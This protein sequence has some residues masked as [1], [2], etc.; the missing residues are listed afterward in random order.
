M[1]TINWVEE[2][3]SEEQRK[4]LEE[5]IRRKLEQEN[6]VKNAAPDDEERKK[7]SARS[8]KRKQS[9]FCQKCG[10]ELAETT[11]FCSS[12]GNAV[13]IAGSTSA[14]SLYW[15]PH[16]EKEIPALNINY[17]SGTAFCSCGRTNML[18][19]DLLSVPPAAQQPQPKTQ[20]IPPEGIK[21]KKSKLLLV[22][23]ILT[24]L[25]IYL[26]VGIF[27]AGYFATDSSKIKQEL[28]LAWENVGKSEEEIQQLMIDF[29]AFATKRKYA[30]LLFFFGAVA[31]GA[32]F[33]TGLVMNIIAYK[34]SD[35]KK[36]KLAGIFW[37]LSI[38]GMY[39]AV[40]CFIACSKLK[41]IAKNA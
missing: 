16:C 14:Y 38:A 37:L 6:T 22:G 15:C 41:K 18:L 10:K 25:G 30:R 1:K 31:L 26:F 21:P 12:C 39:S 5:E 36:A 35:A 3:T 24:F 19:A 7:P 4:K 34:N 29:D 27:A 13:A 32:F 33:I 11:K 23:L 2:T 8:A 40:L 17:D 9:M 28:G 20:N